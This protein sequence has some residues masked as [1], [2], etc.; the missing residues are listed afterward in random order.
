MPVSIMKPPHF[1]TEGVASTIASPKSSPR[2]LKKPASRAR[3]QHMPVRKRAHTTRSM[4][5][6]LKLASPTMSPPKRMLRAKVHVRMTKRVVEKAGV[7]IPTKT[8]RKKFDH[9]HKNNKPETEGSIIF[10]KYFSEVKKNGKHVIPKHYPPY[11]VIVPFA[12]KRKLRKY[13]NRKISIL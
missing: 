7:T 8:T 1:T 3:P 9:T 10:I 5:S 2:A 13:Q 11:T 4:P 12:R 6:T